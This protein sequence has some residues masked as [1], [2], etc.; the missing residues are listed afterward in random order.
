MYVEEPTARMHERSLPSRGYAWYVVFILML[1]QLLAS[2]DAHLPFILVEVLKDDLGLSDTQI[3]LINGPAFSLVYATA[4]IPIARLSDR[5]NRIAIIS[6]AIVI[7]SGFTA[8]AGAAHTFGSL[9]FTRIGVAVGESALT[10]AAHSVIASYLPVSS[11]AKGIAIYSF[12]VA[13]GAFVAF[14]AGGYIGEH[15]GW[16]TAFLAVGGTGLFMAILMLTTVREPLREQRSSGTYVS[17]GSVSRLLKHPVIRNLLAG[18][19]LLGF[20]SGAIESWGPAYVMRTFGLSTTETGMTFGIVMGILAMVG[21]LAG[22]FIASWLSARHPRYALQML[23]IVLVLATIAQVGS[24]VVDSYSQFL[25]LVAITV[26]LSSFYIGP[27]YA[28]LQSMVDSGERSLVSAIALFCFNGMGIAAGTLVVGLL[29]DVLSNY[30]VTHS[31]KWALLVVSF[32]K[33]WSVLHYWLASRKITAF[34]EHFVPPHAG[35]G[36]VVTTAR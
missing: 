30:S 19:A 22:G 33:L 10:P 17:Q 3:G 2:V 29:S 26:L 11:R 27:T 9:A 23:A 34:D 25:V 35:S 8:A 13:V 31:L 5:R 18:G 4:A 21:M 20:S 28:T 36:S 32:V 12:G 7:W 16:R 24:L 15:F 14:A 6:G 1:C